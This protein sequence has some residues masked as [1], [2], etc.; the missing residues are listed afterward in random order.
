MN[1][2]VR[3]QRLVA[4]RQHEKTKP[5]TAGTAADEVAVIAKVTDDVEE[6]EAMH[7]VARGGRRRNRRRRHGY[8]DRS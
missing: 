4:W 8:R 2:D 6:F 7:E 3:L 5:A 1:M